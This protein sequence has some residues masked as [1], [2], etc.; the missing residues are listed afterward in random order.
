LFFGGAA[1][2][3]PPISIMRTSIFHISVIIL[4]VIIVVVLQLPGGGLHA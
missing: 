3:S 2:T 1:L 4:A